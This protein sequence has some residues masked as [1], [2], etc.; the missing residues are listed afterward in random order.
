MIWQRILAA[1]AA[2]KDPAL[3]GEARGM[4]KSLHH[5]WIR[6]EFALLYG[7]ILG[8]RLAPRVEMLPTKYV[9]MIRDAFGFR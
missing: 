7:E 4:R 1:A 5:L 3:V 2:F 8:T 6:N 9:S